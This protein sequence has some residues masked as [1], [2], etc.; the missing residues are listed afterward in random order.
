MQ[1]I[2]MA[3]VLPGMILAQDIKNEDNPDGPPLCG[4]GVHLTDSLIARLH[5]M[6]IQ[7]ITVEGHPA[8]VEG[9]QSLEEELAVLDKRFKKVIDDPLMKKLKDMYRAQIIKARE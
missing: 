4:K 6:D 9:E 5:R 2:P 1:K 7:S 3:L 8:R